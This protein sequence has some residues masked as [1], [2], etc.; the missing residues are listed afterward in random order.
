MSDEASDKQLFELI[1]IGVAGALGLVLFL[2][3]CYVGYFWW[4]LEA[5]LSRDPAAWGAFGDYL[6]GILNPSVAF[7]AFLLLAKSV[8]IQSKELRETTEALRGASTAQ[9][10]QVAVQKAAARMNAMAALISSKDQQVA[11]ANAELQAVTDA[12]VT[13]N[14]IWL[15]MQGLVGAH[16][17][18]AWRLKLAR[19]C[20]QLKVDREGLTQ[21]LN[22]ESNEMNPEDSAQ[23][24]LFEEFN[25]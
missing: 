19:D 14:L 4:Y 22:R 7:F 6:G 9:A 15:H 24:I 25:S 11:M 1:S 12:I 23:S 21:A 17:A 16:A 8:R 5:E 13:S 10:E 2:V 20:A 3:I 18:E